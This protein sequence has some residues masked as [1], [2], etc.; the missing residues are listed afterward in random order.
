MEN[1]RANAAV[2]PDDATPKVSLKQN[3]P[4]R[5]LQNAV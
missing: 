2:L 1:R 4:S 5:C 3:H